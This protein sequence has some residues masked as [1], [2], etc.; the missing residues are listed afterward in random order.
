MKCFHVLAVLGVL[1][2]TGCSDDQATNHDI[3]EEVTTDL[4]RIT[5]M[6]W[7][8]T[9]LGHVISAAEKGDIAAAKS[10]YEYYLV[11]EDD[12]RTAYWESL[13]EERGNPDAMERRASI[14]FS[15]AH[16][17]SD[18][19]PKK[20][21]LLNRAALLAERAQIRSGQ[22][23]RASVLINGNSVDV[24]LGGGDEAFTRK[25]QDEVARVKLIQ[26]SGD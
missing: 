2:V 8:P 4:V 17:L 25:I 19:D 6:D 14:T 24:A 13:L 12:E 16:A 20:L 10:L 22:G 9:E 1:L 3:S 5:N 26:K 21:D 11:H 15:R 18:H 23:E 7:S